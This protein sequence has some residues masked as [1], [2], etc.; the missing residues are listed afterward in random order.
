MTERSEFTPSLQH[1]TLEQRT[2]QRG[3]ADA[4]NGKPCQPSAYGALP[5]SAWETWYTRGYNSE[6]DA[7]GVA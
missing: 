4:L 5:G 7:G 2:M 6:S 3:R 1:D